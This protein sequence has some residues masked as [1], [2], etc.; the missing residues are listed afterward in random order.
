MITSPATILNGNELLNK[1]LP[2]NVAD[3]PN[4]IKTIENPNANKIMGDKFIFFFSNS[5]LRELPEIY[6][7]YPGINGNTHGDRKLI[8]P[9]PK[10]INISAIII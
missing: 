6:E 1:N 5:S 8:K 7:I 9:A 3:A 2:K 10:A 4:T